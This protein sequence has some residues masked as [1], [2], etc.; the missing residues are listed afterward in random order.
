MRLHLLAPLVMA[1]M[2]T[3]QST[4]V[5]TTIITEPTTTEVGQPGATDQPS[6]TEQPSS[7][8]QPL[9]TEQPSSSE[10]VQ[11]GIP[12]AN[13]TS[14]GLPQPTES[15]PP[16][17][18]NQTIVEFLLSNSTNATAFAQIAAGLG[19][20]NTLVQALNSSGTYTCFVPTDSAI[21]NANMTLINETYGGWENIVAYHVL[22]ETIDTANLT[23]LPQ[24]FNTLLT[25]ETLNKLPN[26]TGL[27]L[28]LVKNYNSTSQSEMATLLAENATSNGTI[29]I[30]YG[31]DQYNSLSPE[32]VTASNGI[33][34]YID[35]VLLPPVS[36]TAT[37][38]KK[39]ST[40]MIMQAIEQ[41]NL[42]SQINNASGI[43]FFA[44][45]D[46]AI[47]A[48]NLTQYDNA[49]LAAILKNHVV[50]GVVYTSNITENSTFPS[51][52]GGNLT[53]ANTTTNMT[54]G[55]NTQMYAL[56]K[57]LFTQDSGTDYTVDNATIVDKNVLTN[58]GV[59]QIINQV[60]IPANLTSNGTNSTNGTNGTNGSMPGSAASIT[61]TSYNALLIAL[62]VCLILV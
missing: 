53:L 62:A 9:S 18:Q 57:R 58:N 26:N 52:T 33:I 41:Y 8:E 35:S 20:N 17:P 28:G 19:A 30:G 37:L 31:F 59:I 13:Q 56:L 14:S 2:V 24:F 40:S 45:T 23:T 7:T 55:D 49:T 16:S 1:A 61:G 48:A 22:N 60:L 25:N 32:N 34:Y 10:P 39:T 36:P 11:S 5:V 12:P 47:K 46:E 3:A 43:T 6:A 15:V 44:P 38:A 54:T 42:S 21:K 27:P 4:Q 51:L 29:E 50:Q